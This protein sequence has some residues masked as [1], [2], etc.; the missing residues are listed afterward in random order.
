MGCESPLIFPLLFVDIA[1][2]NN[3]PITYNIRDLC[4]PLIH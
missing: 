3:I 1:G 4:F 2:T